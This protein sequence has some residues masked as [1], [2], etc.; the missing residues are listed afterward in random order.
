MADR[1]R[2]LDAPIRWMAD[3]IRPDCCHCST[4]TRSE[5]DWKNGR[6]TD[7]Q[8]CFSMDCGPIRRLTAWSRIAQ[9]RRAAGPAGSATPMI[10]PA[11]PRFPGRYARP[12]RLGRLHRCL[13]GHRLAPSSRIRPASVPSPGSGNRR[14][15]AG[16]ENQKVF[17]GS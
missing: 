14:C 9:L 5:R 6:S 11:R 15:H 16:A 1:N 10:G 2:R 13:A 17:E 3:R 4:P 12:C 7:Q 8:I